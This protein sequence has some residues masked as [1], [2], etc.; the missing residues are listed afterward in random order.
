MAR[1]PNEAGQQMAVAVRTSMV[2][3]SLLPGSRRV[4]PAQVEEFQRN[5][6]MAATVEMVADLGYSRLTVGGIIRRAHVSRK[7]FHEVFRDREGCFLAVFERTLASARELAT[8]AYAQEPNWRE[9]V[10]SALRALLVFMD[11]EPALARLCVVDALTADETVLEARCEAV[12]E[13]A[14]AI[15]KGRTPG[16]A[17]D[18]PAMTAEAVVG[19][20]SWRFFT[21]DCWTVTGSR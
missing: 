21:A 2:S 11:E 14:R 6:L 5:R 7:T 20:A 13:L 15:D 3:G 1:N 12:E 9:G 10:G 17:H 19:P 18:P 16:A 4:A 8:H